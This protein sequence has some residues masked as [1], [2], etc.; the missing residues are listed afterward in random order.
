MDLGKNKTPLILV[1]ALVVVLGGFVLYQR[2]QQPAPTIPAAAVASPASSTPSLADIA[3]TYQGQ[4]PCADCTG[5]TEEIILTSTSDTGGSYTQTDTYQGKNVAPITENG[6]WT[7]SEENNM[8][9]L[10]LTPTQGQAQY[11]QNSNFTLNPLDQNK[12]PIQS[13]FNQT[14]T[15]K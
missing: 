11:Y 7:V 13:P 3:G 2:S 9:V 12:Q 5:I 10:T 15:K 8:T 14:L 6:N 4:L 1:I